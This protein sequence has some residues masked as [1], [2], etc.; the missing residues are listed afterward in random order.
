M[1]PTLVI[2]LLLLAVPSHNANG[3]DRILGL[4][5]LPELFG[6]GVCDRFT[7]Q[8]L[9]L[10]PAPNGK[11]TTGSVR[12]DDYWTFSDEMSCEGR[13]SV[14]VHY[15]DGSDSTELPTR[16][17]DY[18]RPGAIVLEREDTW[19]RI[20]LAEGSA[21]LRSSEGAEF[22]PLEKLLE[23]GLTYFTEEWDGHLYDSPG[24]A[25]QETPEAPV[26][27]SGVRVTGSRWLN[28]RLWLEVSVLSHSECASAAE[29]RVVRQG[30]VLA[31][32]RSGEPA[33]WFYSRGC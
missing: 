11:D 29:P 23:E 8:D 32:A 7:P 27:A 22:H 16:E 4:L 24:G 1:R 31:H 9:T 28:G 15:A 14:N 5:A 25:R 17:F 30:W 20:R 6:A 18:E 21:W 13:L 19:F 26:S 10:H 2:L 33:V 12:V 3:Q